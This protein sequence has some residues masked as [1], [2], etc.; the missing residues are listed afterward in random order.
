MLALFSVKNFRIFKEEATL[1]L[2]AP[3]GRAPGARPWDGN[4]QA[5]AAIY[6]ANASGKTTLFDAM[7]SMSGQVRESHRRSAVAGDP[8]AFDAGSKNRPTEFRAVFV[9]ADGQ[10]YSYG[11]GVLN[12]KVAF[13]QADLY[14]TPRP[15]LLFKRDADRF[16]FG[17]ALKGPNRAVGKITPPTSLYL[18]AAKASSHPGLEPVADWIGGQL[19][20]YSAHGH[21]SF[22]DNAVRRLATDDAFRDRTVGMLMRADLGLDDLEYAELDLS[23]EQKAIYQRVKAMLEGLSD[24]DLDDLLEVPNKRFVGF[25][26]HVSGG[27][28]HK[29]PIEQESEG[30]RAM[31]SH[32]LAVDGA[33]TTGATAVFDEI[34]SSLHPLLLRRLVEVFQDRDANPKQAQL[35]FT[36]HDVSLMEAGYG[37]GSQLSRDEVWI[38]ERDIDGRSSLAPL[39]DYAPRQREN[40]ARRYLSGRFGG[41]PQ[42]DRLVDPVLF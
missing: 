13:E 9:A 39:A 4:L 3:R 14:A 36:T 19:H 32:A 25:G 8:F 42:P 6:G 5:V 34:D 10:C 23:P 37:G 38:T 17:S 35:I 21:R 15:T 41:I 1:D 31:L 40:L 16:G 28:Q 20:T 26:I 33:L 24:A 11:F 12:G 18:S 30:T 22:L 29:V 2:R 27:A 7:A